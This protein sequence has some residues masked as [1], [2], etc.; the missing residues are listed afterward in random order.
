[1]GN[2]EPDDTTV[3]FDNYVGTVVKAYA[4][5]AVIAR[6]EVTGLASE[7]PLVGRIALLG[8]KRAVAAFE[9]D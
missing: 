3:R 9:Q 2:R 7:A 8:A 6:L 5:K 4:P 1:V